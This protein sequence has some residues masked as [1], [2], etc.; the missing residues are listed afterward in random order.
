MSAAVDPGTLRLYELGLLPL[1]D[2]WIDDSEGRLFVAFPSAGREGEVRL[3]VEMMRQDY[4][5]VRGAFEFIVSDKPFP[6]SVLRHLPAA[7]C[8][9]VMRPKVLAAAMHS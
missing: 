9:M 5:V 7:K 4:L 2:P 1:L 8:A 6:E 3:A